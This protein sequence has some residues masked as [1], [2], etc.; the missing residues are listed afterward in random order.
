MSIVKLL[1]QLADRGQPLRTAPLTQLTGLTDE[2]RTELSANWPSLPVERRRQIVERLALIAE[3]NVEMDFDAVF[4]EALHDADAEVRAGAILGL[5]EYRE[6]DLIPHLVDLVERDSSVAVRA[7]AAL[8]LGR[9][10]VLGEFDEA[11]PRDVEQV[12]T[13]LRAVLANTAEVVEVRARA[14]EA[15]GA[16]SAPW[17]RD[18]I[19]DAY[20]S[21]NDAFLIAALRAMGR[22]ADT[23]W[24]P[25]V[26]AEMQSGSGELR[27]EAAA[28]A[29]SIED[30]EAV[31]Y[32]VELLDD[33]DS[34]VREQAVASLG[35]IGGEEAIEALRLRL[36]QTEDIDM[37]EAIQSALDEAEFGDDPLGFSVGR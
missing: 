11:R 17:V 19:H 28:A 20:A 3:D 26:I 4:F 2:E 29:G 23:Y 14:V 18:I 5:W 10:V 6:R 33:D 9:F 36:Q 31:P 35:E 12:T 21:G 8:G 22:S 25:T 7:E 24:L 27:F 16:S 30:E 1:N 13:T 32:L 37:R 34:E 15:L